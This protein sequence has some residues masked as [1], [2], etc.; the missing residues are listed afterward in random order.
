MPGLVLEG[1]S[2]RA[3]FSAGVMDA[4]LEANILFPYVIGVSAG[5]SNGAAYLSGQKGRNLQILLTYPHD[6]RYV[7]RRNYIKYRSLF[8]IDFIFDEIPNRLI[9]YDWDSFRA[10]PGRAFA[11]AT[12]A[13]TGLPEYLD[14]ADLDSESHIL[15][16]TCALPLLFPA[17]EWQ[18]KLYYDGGLTDSIPAQRALDDGND[19][20]L[21]VL[22][23]PKG[24]R[25]EYPR[26]YDL[27]IRFLGKR[28]PALPDVLR[29]RHLRYNAELDFCEKLEAEGKAVILRPE[30]P[31]DG[32]EKDLDRIRANY[33]H[34]F[35]LAVGQMDSIRSLFIKD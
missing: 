5:I 15:R 24:F 25:K 8:G 3:I 6:P 4:L 32:M 23:Q 29:N 18:D 10:Y 17:I 2:L 35:D 16:A 13:D 7:G 21:I 27:A 9:P 22:T 28:F 20:L 19:K 26:E 34:G 14:L 11:V 30:Y 33:K 12:N 31:L 1:G